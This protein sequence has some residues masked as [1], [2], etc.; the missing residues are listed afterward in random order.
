MRNQKGITLIALVIT[1]IV[2]LILAGVAIAM[3]GGDNGILKKASN[4]AKDTAVSNVKEQIGLLVNEAI[5]DYYDNVYVNGTP[6]VEAKGVQV[7][8]SEKLATL[9]GSEYNDI[10]FTATSALTAK[11]EDSAYY[12]ITFT[13][14]GDKSTFT[15]KVDNKGKLTWNPVGQ[16]ATTPKAS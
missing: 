16:T 6:G 9:T 7:A 10:T 13:Y 15:A 2:L 5:T 8:I 4:S 12:E 14:D 3:L 1:I 11:T